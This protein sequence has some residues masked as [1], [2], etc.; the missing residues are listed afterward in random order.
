MS[1][2]ALVGLFQ[3]LC[4]ELLADLTEVG[5]EYSSILAVLLTWPLFGGMFQNDL[6]EWP[7]G[8]WL[9]ASLPT[10]LPRVAD[11]T[12]KDSSFTRSRLGFSEVFRSSGCFQFV[13]RLE[14]VP[15]LVNGLFEVWKFN[16][17]LNWDVSA[18]VN[19]TRCVADRSSSSSKLPLLLLLF[20]L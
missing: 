14:K 3:G 10:L 9:L 5:V 19:C 6:T 2:P 8:R 17:L 7:S 18:C 15:S 1:P 4:L 13:P 20:S 11:P 16:L 12:M